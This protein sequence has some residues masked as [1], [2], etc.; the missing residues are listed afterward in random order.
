MRPNEPSRRS[1]RAVPGGRDGAPPGS[2]RRSPSRGGEGTLRAFL[3]PTIWTLAA[4]I[5]LVVL[6][7]IVT[8]RAV[9][10]REAPPAPDAQAF[11]SLST[12]PLDAGATAGNAAG[13]D[14]PP[15]QGQPATPFAAGAE[16]SGPARAALAVVEEAERGRTSGALSMARKRFEPCP[17]EDVERLAWIDVW[18]RIV[19]MTGTRA[20]PAAVTVE[21]WFDHEGRLRGVR[22]TRAGAGGWSLNALLD[23]RGATVQRTATGAA[24]SLEELRLT[25]RDP[26][27][28]FFETPRCE[29]G[30]R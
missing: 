29:P 16:L 13:G 11:Q 9:R 22:A 26:S 2:A 3:K 8:L 7:G 24:A 12:R 14:A 5:G 21:Q 6:T 23:E 18:S 19:K 25:T 28:A 27:S 1:P 10:S 17:G 4:S 15:A 30:E 20:G